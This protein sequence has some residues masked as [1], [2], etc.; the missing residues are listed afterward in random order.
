MDKE[1]ELELVHMGLPINEAYRPVFGTV[2]VNSEKDDTPPGMKIELLGHQKLLLAE[3]RKK[4]NEAPTV[5]FVDNKLSFVSRNAMVLLET[6]GSGKSYIILAR[7]LQQPL[8]TRKR[9]QPIIVS[10]YKNCTINTVIDISHSVGNIVG[11]MNWIVVSRSTVHQW[12][13]YLSQT[14]LSFATITS[15]K[16]VDNCSLF[17]HKQVWLIS[18]N[19]YN[20]IVIDCSTKASPS[21][22]IPSRIIFDNCDAL[23]IKNVLQHTSA[24]Y[25]FVSSSPRNIFHPAG[26]FYSGTIYGDGV[27]S[28]GFIKEMLLS[29]IKDR[30]SIIVKAPYRYVRE[31]LALP[32]KIEQT[33][34]IRS[35]RQVNQQHTCILSPEVQLMLNNNEYANISKHYHMQACATEFQILEKI[36]DHKDNK[37][38]RTRFTTND[39]CNVCYKTKN[40]PLIEDKIEGLCIS[41]CCYSPWCMRCIIYWLDKNSSCPNCRTPLY[42]SEMIPI[43]QQTQYIPPLVIYDTK[44]IA[45]IHILEIC[46]LKNSKVILFSEFEEGVAAAE[47]LCN[48]MKIKTYTTKGKNDTIK[49]CISQWSGS[50]SISVLL[51][52]EKRCGVGLNLHHATD[53]ILFNTGERFDVKNHE[54]LG[55]VIRYGVKTS[56]NVWRLQYLNE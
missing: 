52:A 42:I 37:V 23:N 53:V 28:D 40:P 21:D 19:R 6:T 50:S 30:S 44:N 33:F 16:H 12:V 35:W 24:F 3:M 20:S 10:S 13:H 56:P 8:L 15:K 22:Y 38:I 54:L 25:W 5:E 34:I 41:P 1:D 18:E 39:T 11:H 9:I 36:P 45:I 26:R 29:A 31:C 2:D 47:Q 55:R 46:R 51:L 48:T 43:A 27:E 17:K 32:V 49:R 7:I 14:S 4:E